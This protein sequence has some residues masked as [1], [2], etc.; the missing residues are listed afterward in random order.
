MQSTIDVISPRRR[1]PASGLLLVLVV[2]LVAGLA[3]IALWK[4]PVIAQSG[5]SRPD[6]EALR[7]AEGLSQAFRHAA[8]MMLPT[9]VQIETHSKPKARAT[10]GPRQVPF[11]GENPF[12]GTPF[13]D[14]FK[15]FDRFQFEEGE[16]PFSQPREGLGSGVIIDRS[17]V[18]LTNN[19]VIDGADAVTVRL[20]DGRE[21]KTTKIRRDK[22]TDL[23]LVWIDA[24]NLPAARLG[25]SDRAKIGDWV[26][27]IGHP[28]H[29]DATVS[30]GIISSKG[31]NLNG[32]RRTTFLQ[33]DAA[34]NPG[35]S[36]GPLVNL[37]GE[38]VGINTAI[39]SRTGA[40]SGIGFA[41]PVNTV[42][43]VVNELMQRDNVQRAY[44]GAGIQEIT[45]E[46]AQRLGVTRRHGVQVAEV[47]PNSPAEKAGLQD[48][49]IVREFNG[50]KVT[51]PSELQQAVER[52]PTGKKLPVRVHRS[53]KELTLNV[54][55]EP[56]P[57]K[58]ATS[59]PAVE[60]EDGETAE[61]FKSEELGLELS[62]MTPQVAKRLGYEG[63]TGVLISRVE[64]DSLAHRKGL[65]EG[66]LVLKV[67]DKRVGSV[68]EFEEALKRESVKQGI[69]LQIRTPSGNRFLVLKEL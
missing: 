67:G 60:R 40:F 51:M 45:N 47:H 33:T 41:V 38:V 4:A 24:S 52:S 64:P 58:L 36:G 29:L 17:G 68:A 35:N 63:H 44:L 48:G 3:T 18:I 30:A 34:I 22:E 25:D 13:E 50:V 14:M 8:D 54:E 43:W 39:F 66:M 56:L 9:V 69:L 65:R 16:S 53:G 7:H 23:A 21:F 57:E 2:A 37:A 49:D 11:G 55:L 31:R 19:H 32:V 5:L 26:L 46:M 62:D 59:R 10:R 15:D 20:H 1:V 42:K 27:A 61:S 6:N 12:K 28:F